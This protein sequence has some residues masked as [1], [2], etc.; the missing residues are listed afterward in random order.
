MLEMFEQNVVFKVICA[1]GLFFLMQL[2]FFWSKLEN[3]D[4]KKLTI[5]AEIETLTRKR[6]NLQMKS[7]NLQ[8]DIHRMELR[9][10]QIEE[11]YVS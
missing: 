10:Q 11:K 5:E 1:V 2:M 7:W 6:D 4:D 3:L 8:K 9:L